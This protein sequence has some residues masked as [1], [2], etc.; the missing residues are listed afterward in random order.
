LLYLGALTLAITGR[1]VRA[2]AWIA[3]MQMSAAG[4]T[5][6]TAFRVA[7]TTALSAFQR[8]DSTRAVE[9]LEPLLP[10]GL[11]G[12]TAFERHVFLSTLVPSLAAAGRYV[13]AHSLLNSY[14]TAPDDDRDET[15]LFMAG[16]R[17]V[18]LLLEGKVAEAERAST[19]DRTVAVHGGRS[20]WTSMSA[21]TLASALYEQNRI[22][23]ARELLANRLHTLGASSSEIMIRAVLCQARLDLL[24]NPAETALA[25][26]DRQANFFR[27]M[28]LD[29]AFLYM[30]AEQVRILIT[31]GDL[32][33]ATDTVVRLEQVA[34]S[35]ANADGFRAEIPAVA[36]LARARL[37]LA[38]GNHEDALHAVM[39]TQAIADRLG[40]GLMMVVA[41]VIAASILHAS[42]RDAEGSACLAQ[43][44]ELASRLGL[45]RV[46]VDEGEGTYLQL[47]RLRDDGV[48][49]SASASYVDRLLG[50]FDERRTV[51]ADDA[52]GDGRTPLTPRE[53]EM[54][55]LIAAGMSNKRIAHTLNIALET[56]KWNLKNVFIKLKVS[57]RYDATTRARRL[58]LIK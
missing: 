37:E 9:L 25:L 34:A 41:R 21:A 32:Q 38:R 46:F 3:Q 39:T 4:N 2:A 47:R 22:D 16:G 26:L 35:F 24:Q 43:A 1:H 44:V 36:A 23:D 6:E 55:N 54:V 7:L 58:G 48:L 51:A 10:H 49:D 8:D 31:K 12:K 18:I 33:R 30:G 17:P 57:N 53:L 42:G 40:R 15:A 45:L 5:R 29:R 11:E 14:L 13:E 50:H 52:G 20:I 27:S 19:Y 56:V 28:G